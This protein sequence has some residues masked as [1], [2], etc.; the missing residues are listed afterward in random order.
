[1]PIPGAVLDI[2]GRSSTAQYELVF[3]AEDL[4][5][6]GICQY[7]IEG[8]PRIF[9]SPSSTRKHFL[10]LRDAIITKGVSN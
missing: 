8:K 6:L 7:H 2:P 5:P 4:P 1:M 9:V 10:P 3:M